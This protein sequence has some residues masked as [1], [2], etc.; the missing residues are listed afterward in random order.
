M[1]NF[2]L[3]S[4]TRN[5]MQSFSKIII[6]P[7]KFSLS[8]KYSSKVCQKFIDC[9]IQVFGIPLSGVPG[10]EKRGRVCGGTLI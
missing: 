2:R 9:P 7:E 8:E 10:E 6:L 5:C 4:V 1:Q 3:S